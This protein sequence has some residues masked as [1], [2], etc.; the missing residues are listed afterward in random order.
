[1]NFEPVKSA[2]AHL[3]Q[4][5]IGTEEQL[6]RTRQQL[7]EVRSSLAGLVA[8]AQRVPSATAQADLRAELTA[9][10]TLLDRLYAEP[11]SPQLE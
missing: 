1:M 10:Q 4:H 6:S 7:R 2:L 11:D 8:V 9:A 5:A 3:E